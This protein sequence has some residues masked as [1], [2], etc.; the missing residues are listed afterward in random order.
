MT[1]DFKKQTDIDAFRNIMKRVR[2]HREA[3]GENLKFVL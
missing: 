3:T 1:D 2:K